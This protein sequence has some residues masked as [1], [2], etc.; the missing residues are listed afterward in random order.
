MHR[1]KINPWIET[2]CL[3]E[4]STGQSEQR[5]K[6]QDNQPMKGKASDEHIFILISQTCFELT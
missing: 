6:G 4:P 3:I 1:K 5:E 2:F